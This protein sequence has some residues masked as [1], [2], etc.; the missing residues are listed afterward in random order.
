MRIA[1]KIFNLKER[2]T[3]TKQIDVKYNKLISIVDKNT[4]E[5]IDKKELIDMIN[6]IYEFTKIMVQ[7]LLDSDVDVVLPLVF[8]SGRLREYNKLVNKL[9]QI[10]V[11][12]KPSFMRYKMLSFDQSV[13]KLVPPKVDK[14]TRKYTDMKLLCKDVSQK[15]SIN[16][17]IIN[18]FSQI[19]K[20]TKKNVTKRK[21]K[22]END[23]V[24]NKGKIK[25]K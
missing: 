22:G 4:S 11:K 19:P 24:T 8:K 20:I 16:S 21:I 3:N 2:I 18:Q 23:T 14:S 17:K 15:S 10:Y 9:I 12:Y 1:F 13:I 7:K 5:K 6:N 25:S